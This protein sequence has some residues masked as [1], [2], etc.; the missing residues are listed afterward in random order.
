MGMQQSFT[1]WN[2]WDLNNY[3]QMTGLSQPQLQQLQTAFNQQAAA[4]GGRININ[5][6]KNIYSSIN[7]L[8]WNLNA[9]AENAFR[10]F[11]TDGNGVLT[12][13]EFLMGY[14]MLQRGVNPAQRWT[15][16]ANNYPLSRPGYLSQQEAQ[17]L[18]GNM[19]QFYN[20]PLQES[21]FETA[22]SQV[23]GASGG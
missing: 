14:L 9:D 11:D 20:F 21:Y 13:D 22:W 2:N 18:L 16:A 15:Y 5:Q 19:Q 7:G 8:S 17:M 3:S 4:T 12:L 1:S 23:G 10:M 6:F